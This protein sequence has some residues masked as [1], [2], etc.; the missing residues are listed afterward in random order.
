M[1]GV[2]A[3]GAAVVP[4]SVDQPVAEV[5]WCVQK[6]GC[7]GLI[8]ARAVRGLAGEVASAVQAEDGLDAPVVLEA[9]ECLPSAPEFRAEDVVVSSGPCLDD[10]KP[11][12][13][14]FTSGTTGRPKGCVLRRLYTHESA[15]TVIDS[16]DIS[17]EDT[18][19]HVLPVHHATG[20]GTSFFPF[21]NAGAWICF[22]SGS[23]EPA[24]VW[25]K[26]CDGTV[27]VFSG[28]PTM[29]MRLMWYYEQKSEPERSRYDHGAR[30]LRAL[31]C[32]SSALQQRVQDFWTAVRNG[33]PIL[34]R[35]GS[36]EVPSVIRTP[37]RLDPATIPRGC[38]GLPSPGLDWKIS[39]EG[40]LL[41][42][43][44]FMFSKYLHDR[45]ATVE[46]HTSEGYFRTGD[47]AHVDEQ[48]F[49]FIDGRVSTDIIKSGGYKIGAP[50]IERA[51]LA[52]PY[53]KEVMVVGVEDEEF[54]Q[55]VG[56]AVVLK[57]A[58]DQLSVT[59]L[60]TDLKSSDR[61]SVV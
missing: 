17:A 22:R 3:L 41:L 7:V 18:V 37:A 29:Y 33:R 26:I 55:R 9:M 13:V 35:Y 11:A 28:V 32:G 45:E 20:I 38:V 49:I 46:A 58:S 27:T 53:V 21:M 30:R 19:L 43:S 15:A 25:E 40:E 48:G 2:L 31:L 24:W 42:R 57:S 8:C 4:L 56:A 59:R 16:F 51:L 50:D 47:L 52:L 44:P 14:I 34:V 12:L 5:G 39:D 60:R 6:A 23:F 54:G 10:G 1:L 61:K 36:S